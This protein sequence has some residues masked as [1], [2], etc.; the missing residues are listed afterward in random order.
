MDDVDSQIPNSQT[1]YSDNLNHILKST[2][3]IRIVV[4]LNENIVNPIKYFHPPRIPIRKLVIR[5]VL[6]IRAKIVNNSG[7]MLP[8][9][10]T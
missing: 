3:P 2:P 5:V 8:I 10:L 4:P 6:V 1:Y 7:I 9:N